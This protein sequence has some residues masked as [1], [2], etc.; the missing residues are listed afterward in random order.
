MAERVLKSQMSSVIRSGSGA[1]TK[2]SEPKRWHIKRRVV[3][4]ATDATLEGRRLGVKKF[5]GEFVV[6]GNII[7][8][9]RGTKWHPGANVGIGKDHT[10]FALL[11][12][13]VD[14]R[15]RRDVSCERRSIPANRRGTKI[16]VVFKRIPPAPSNPVDSPQPDRLASG[17]GKTRQGF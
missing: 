3:R 2:V 15:A 13:P 16:T 12:G 10:L 1:R 6:G 5:G 11:D 17:P 8:R 9:Q 7:A 14:F 4:L